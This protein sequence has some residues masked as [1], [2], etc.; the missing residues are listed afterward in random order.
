MTFQRSPSQVG[1]PLYFSIMLLAFAALG[2]FALPL[3]ISLLPCFPPLSLLAASVALWNWAWGIALEPDGLAVYSLKGIRFTPGR[4]LAGP[5][6]VLTIGIY[7]TSKT[8]ISAPSP[9]RRPL[10]APSLKS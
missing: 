2:V 6:L 4:P 5:S 3:T 7:M 9:L 1:T 8:G 10:Q